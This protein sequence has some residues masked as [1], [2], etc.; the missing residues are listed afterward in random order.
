MGARLLSVLS[1]SVIAAA[2]AASA[3]A[4][5]AA[6]PED[7]AALRAKAEAQG[8]V[9]VIMRVA[10]DSAPTAAVTAL[11]AEGVEG[12]QVLV[13][14]A[15]LVVAEISAEEFDAIYGSDLYDMMM[16]DYIA[17]PTLAQSGP[18]ITAPALWARGGRGAGQAVAILDT[19]VD[20]A[21]SFLAGRVV[22]EACFSTTSAATGA[23]SVCPNGQ[24]S[25]T[26]AGAARPCTANGCEHGTH[27]AGIAAGRGEAFSG[28]APDAD[29][30]AVQVFSL[31]S[32]SGGASPCRDS[33]QASPCIA[34]FTSDQIRG[35]AHV[36]DV[37]ER[38]SVAAANM[39][40][41]G[42]RA[43]TACD[44]DLTKPIID[45]LR[46]AGVA[47]VIAAG[48]DGF[49]DAVSRPGCISTAV[50]AGAT[51]KQDQIAN[52][53]NRGPQVDVL[54]PGASINSSVPNNRFAVFSGTSMAAPHVAGA[55]ASLRSLHTNASVAD[56]ES[57]LRSTGVAVQNRPRIALARAEEALAQAVSGADI[58][59]TAMAANVDGPDLSLVP[60]DRVLRMILRLRTSEGVGGVSAAEAVRSATNAAR[61]AGVETIETVGD[62]PLIVIEA[63]PRQYAIIAGAGG[64]ESMQI[65]GVAR[66]Q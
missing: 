48:N 66:T 13:A 10:A 55:F 9:R 21:H 17:R 12:A 44:T 64:V 2:F 6:L 33:G 26:G 24:P 31:F 25:Q 61:A 39:S 43:T 65:D 32:D 28:I 5:R 3:C 47:T 14:G 1:A 15:P 62:Q 7:M 59:V 60:P 19:G 38:R 40:L 30:I 52:F 45:D 37:A 22:D 50:T 11:A 53:S 8:A 41:G 63:T 20:A 57:A 34:S 42:G 58:G 54:A 56:I 49:P 51:T 16:E 18:L 35:L 27:V 46:A 23:R 29:I 4:P 36:R